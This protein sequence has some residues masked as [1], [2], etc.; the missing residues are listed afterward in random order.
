MSEPYNIYKEAEV[1]QGSKE[2]Y[3][4]FLESYFKI[5]QN[6][7]VLEIGPSL[8]HHTKKILKN[9][10]AYLE[11]IEGFESHIDHLKSIPGVDQVICND[12]YDELN[13]VKQFDLVVCFGVLYHLH[14]PLYLLELIVNN[15]RP[16]FLMMDCVVEM[17]NITVL[18]EKVNHDG[19][20]Q[21]VKNWKA[22]PV[23]IVLPFLTYKECLENMGYELV[24][25]YLLKISTI[26]KKNSW[27]ATWKLKENYDKPVS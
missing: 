1:I 21:T 12:V 4:D 20:R 13:K 11:L 2:K 10:P 3:L 25:T 24:N 18:P 19:S 16:K 14:S 23:N 7:T 6:K 5:C 22:A 26:A 27:L 15:C 17:E 9:N 8:G